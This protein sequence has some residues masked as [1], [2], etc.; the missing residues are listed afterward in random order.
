M[1]SNQSKEVSAVTPIFAT[2]NLHLLA[3]VTQFLCTHT[4]I[5]YSHILIV[6]PGVMNGFAFLL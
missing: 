5:G 6:S 4:L 3:A 2:A 1:A